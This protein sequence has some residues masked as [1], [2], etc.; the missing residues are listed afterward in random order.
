MYVLYLKDRLG[1]H[2]DRFAAALVSRGHRVER[3][4]SVGEN[5]WRFEDGRAVDTSGLLRLGADVLQAGPIPVAA[6]LSSIVK[7]VSVVTTCWG[8][9][10]YANLSTREISVLRRSTLILCDCACIARRLQRAAV[11]PITTVC[12]PWGIDL[13]M[14]HPPAPS[15]EHRDGLRLLATRSLETLYDYSTILRGVGRAVAAGA[16]LRLDIYGTGSQREHLARLRDSL[17]LTD[18]VTLRDP[19]PEGALADAMRTADAWV[20]ASHSDGISVSLLQ[21]L[22]SGC[23]IVT[24][25][26]ECAR[27]AVGPISAVRFFP[28]GD[29]SL[30]GEILIDIS[31]AAP[32]RSVKTKAWLSQYANW[33]TNSER[34]VNA[35]ADAACA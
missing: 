31:G 3:A 23:G 9:D 1:V 30:L 13:E 6:L 7:D 5:D 18:R 20:N 16:D 17:A 11:V 33:S 21:A 35:I 8:T 4:V 29:D 34:Y 15:G 27:E 22:A 2:D 25:D 28:P 32:E 14:F 26:L 12:F 10:G 24:T 19:L